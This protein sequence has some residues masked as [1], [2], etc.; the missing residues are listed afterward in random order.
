MSSRPPS[1]PP[2]L[3]GYE[4]ERLLGSGGFA[5][6]FLYRQFRPQRSVAI[7]VLLSSVLDETVRR[8]F[9]AEANVMAT[10][11]THPS[12]VT[13]HQADVS[14]DHR[15][16]IVMEFCSRPNYGVRFRKER[17]SVSEAIRVG[18]QIAGAVET[19]HRA[20]ILH[21]DIKPANILVTD[22]NRPALTDFGISIATAH[23]EDVEDSQGMSIPWSPPEFF[24]DPPRADVRSDVF[25]LAATVYSLLASQTPFERRGQ[26]NTAADLISR[27]EK[28]PL[29]P[30]E[31]PDVPPELNR[32]LAIAMAKNPDGRYD[33]ALAFGRALQQVEQ[34]LALPVTQM[35]VLDD[36]GAPASLTG[37]EDELD[38]HTR[39]RRVT[40]ISAQDGRPAGSAPSAPAAQRPGQAA[41]PGRRFAPG[42]PQSSQGSPASRPSQLDRYAGVAPALTSA[43]HARRSALSAS[44]ANGPLDDATQLRPAGAAAASH[45]PLH[46]VPY[47]EED[48]EQGAPARAVMWPYILLAAVLVIGLGLGTTLAVR[49]F[50]G[51][52]EAER[53]TSALNGPESAGPPPN[54][55]E[56]VVVTVIAPEQ[57]GGVPG[58]AQAAWRL[59][60]GFTEEDFFEVRWAGMPAN[61]EKFSTPVPVYGRSSRVLEMPPGLKG[62]CVEVRTN[63]A[64]G[65][66]SEWV[67][68]CLKN[69]G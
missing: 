34:V 61:Y 54:P 68:G 63:A 27:I 64:D 57:D 31:R 2:A 9:D 1:A 6:V 44:S 20:G 25:A 14:A 47:E 48:D 22:Y 3:A 58:R 62:R 18:V 5:D 46:A 23:G 26:R 15:P 11:S 30:L 19:A 50:V 40:T 28:E 52:P 35:D 66:S 17:I 65:Q 55:P 29:R 41:L 8:Q 49:H 24:S 33:S 43:E 36:R 32:V 60:E 59:P 4:F 51:D 10:M 16:Y 7:K 56:D 69:D 39:I 42:T 67:K 38:S 45:Q 37:E 13:I 21:R 53:P 12:I